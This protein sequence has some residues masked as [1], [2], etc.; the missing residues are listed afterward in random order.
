MQPRELCLVTMV[1]IH[2]KP[3]NNRLEQSIPTILDQ[4]NRGEAGPQMIVAVI[5]VI[6]AG[7]ALLGLVFDIQSALAELPAF[8]WFWATLIALLLVGAVVLAA[9]GYE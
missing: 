8:N 9:L 7:P 6:I 1:D 4:T 3:L 5:I 2:S